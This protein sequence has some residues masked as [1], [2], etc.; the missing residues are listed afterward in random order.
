M[1]PFLRDRTGRI[2]CLTD[3]G[4]YEPIEK[5]VFSPQ[6]LNSVLWEEYLEYLIANR[7]TLNRSDMGYICS[8]YKLNIEGFMMY[9]I[10]E[11]TGDLGY[12]ETCQDGDK[13]LITIPCRSNVPHRECL[14]CH[15]HWYTLRVQQT[16][17]GQCPF[18]RGGFV[19][20][21]VEESS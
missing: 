4:Q 12:C 19:Y 20:P 18:C 2:V 17:K 13:E 14:E 16:G 1:A 7:I 6:L 15:F 9:P 5:W 3:S 11:P 21:I 8:M 10:P